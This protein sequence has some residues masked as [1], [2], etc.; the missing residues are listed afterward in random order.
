MERRLGNESVSPLVSGSRVLLLPFQVAFG[1]QQSRV[2][3]YRSGRQQHTARN[4]TPP[5]TRRAIGKVPSSCT[6]GGV[7]LIHHAHRNAQAAETS[8][9][10]LSVGST[11]HCNC[12]N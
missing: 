6:Q 9:Q 1:D 10:I 12:C 8:A 7:V 2:I 11:T 3:I 4:E 5:A